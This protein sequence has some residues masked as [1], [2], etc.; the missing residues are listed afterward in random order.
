MK[1][2]YFFLVVL[3]IYFIATQIYVYHIKSLP[4]DC[5]QEFIARQK[6]KSMINHNHVRVTTTKDRKKICTFLN[7]SDDN[8]VQV[9]N[10][11]L[12]KEN[13]TNTITNNLTKEESELPTA[14]E[15]IDLIKLDYVDFESQYVFN[16]VNLPVTTRRQFG[17]SK[18]D[19]LYL[20]SIYQYLMGWNILF[21]KY[22]SIDNILLNVLKIRPIFAMETDT[23]FILQVNVSL[24]YLNR[25]LHLELVFNGEIQ[26]SDDII[27]EPVD[28]CFLQLDRIKLIP[29]QEFDTKIF[30]DVK[31]NITDGILDGGQFVSMDEQLKYV[32]KINRMH[33]NE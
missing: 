29:K 22:C 4:K 11:G 25:T 31:D 18:R 15:L 24:F 20:K 27:N 3:A 7:S 21:R 5:Q 8:Q 14:R 13:F 12:V 9:Q 23:E 6:L 10:R 30:E 1:L 16:S 17:K 26:R 32:Q 2:L 19:K 33:E 28:Q